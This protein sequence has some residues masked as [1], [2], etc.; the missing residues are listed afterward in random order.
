MAGCGQ[1]PAAHKRL[2][3]RI[4]PTFILAIRPMMTNGSAMRALIGFMPFVV[5]PLKG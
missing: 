1:P 5:R 4:H 3:E 2:G